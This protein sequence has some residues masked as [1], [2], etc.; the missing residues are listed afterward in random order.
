MSLTNITIAMKTVIFT[1]E[2]LNLSRGLIMKEM[3][4]YFPIVNNV[5]QFFFK[6]PVNLVHLTQ[7]DRLIEWDVTGNLGGLA[8]NDCQQGGLDYYQHIPIISDLKDY[9][10]Y[11]AGSMTQLFLKQILH[12]ADIRD[13]QEFT[14]HI[15]PDELPFA[16]CGVFHSNNRYCSLSK[17]WNIR[18]FMDDTKSWIL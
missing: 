8:L 4:L 13:I 3:T 14:S 1:C 18:K 9:T 16:G 11:V 15:Y 5:R 6:R 2:G 10:I 7:A 12:H 17:M